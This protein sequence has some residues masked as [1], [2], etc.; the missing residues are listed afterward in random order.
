MFIPL[1]NCEETWAIKEKK[2]KRKEKK[3]RRENK[4]KIGDLQLKE[5]LHLA[6][7]Y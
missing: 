7:T 5:N 1:G 6:D 4:V 2:R 3:G